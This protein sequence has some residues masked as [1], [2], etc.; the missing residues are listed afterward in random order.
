MP[1][2]RTQPYTQG[3]AVA[4]R[5]H[6]ATFGDVEI[7]ARQL[8][9]K[10]GKGITLGPIE[11]GVGGALSGGYSA[12]GSIGLDRQLSDDENRDLW[13]QAFGVH[14]TPKAGELEDKE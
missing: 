4:I 5:L 8:R 10:H 3:V 2:K 14:P 7:A 1:K 13:S 6:G 9:A 12:Y 11:P